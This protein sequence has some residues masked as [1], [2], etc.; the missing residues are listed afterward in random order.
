MSSPGGSNADGYAGRLDPADTTSPFN[1]SNFQIAQALGLVRTALIVKVMAVTNVDEPDKEIGF[2]D[3]LP[4]VNML[5]GA[6]NATQHITVYGMPYVRLQGGTNAIIMD[7]KV[8]DL[9]IAVFADR[10]ISTVKTTKKQANPGSLRRHDLADGMYIGGLLNAV[11]EQYVRFSADGIDL[12]DKN[13]N[14][15]VMN[16]DGITINGVLFDRSQNVSQIAK[17]TSTDI[18]S[19]AGGGKK[20][21]LDGDAVVAGVVVAS[22]TKTLAT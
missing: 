16:T 18:A 21:V 22:S 5:D 14:T 17:L 10:D 8:G 13:G 15:L 12:K 9:G 3:V 11:P 1:A 4:L 20:V 2:V 7:P 19:L 6:S